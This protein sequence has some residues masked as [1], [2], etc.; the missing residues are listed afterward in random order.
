MPNN[1]LVVPEI[2]ET[3]DD[4]GTDTTDWTAIAVAQNEAAKRFEGTSKRNY[5]DLQRANTELTALK[6]GRGEKKEDPEPSKTDNNEFGYAQ[7][8]YWK[9]EGVSEEDFEFLENEARTTGKELYDLLKYN[10]VKEELKNRKDARNVETNTPSGKRSTAPARDTKDFWL[11]KI[12]KGDATV[13]DIEDRKLRKEVLD[14]RK[15]LHTNKIKY[16]GPSVL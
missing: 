3:K 6:S 9:A 14:A 8:A 4:Q 12:E 2:E 5:S 7:R 16:T 13:L 10:Y 15:E 11:A 1:D